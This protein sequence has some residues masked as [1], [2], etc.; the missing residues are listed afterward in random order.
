MSDN[1]KIRRRPYTGSCHCGHV[2]FIVYLSFPDLPYP[3]TTPGHFRKQSGHR[4]YKCNCT[5]CHKAGL[6]HIRIPD[7]A[8]DFFVLSPKNPLEAGSGLTSYIPQGCQGSWH[9]CQRCG[10]RGFSVR[11]TGYDG[12][13]DLPAALLQRLESRTLNGKTGPIT[14]SENEITKIPAWRPCKDWLESADE[15]EENEP[16]QYLSINGLCL[17]A[18]NENLD[19]RQLHDN[20]YI[21]YMQTLEWVGME[22]EEKPYSGGA[23]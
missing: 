10:I 16:R 15:D 17:D 6:L 9:F 3:K 12:E 7:P 11:G 22:Y 13:V 18:H 19:L 20:G 5:I 14:A 23:Y 2:K 4:I 1:L 21:A 8:N